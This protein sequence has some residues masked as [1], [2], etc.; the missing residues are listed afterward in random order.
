MIPMTDAVSIIRQSVCSAPT[1]EK[2]PLGT[3]YFPASVRNV[4]TNNSR[5][6]AYRNV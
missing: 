4:R 1:I 3:L 6:H 2:T 5:F